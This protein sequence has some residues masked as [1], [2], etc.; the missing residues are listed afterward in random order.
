MTAL[1]APG[2]SRDSRRCREERNFATFGGVKR[3][4]G[5]VEEKTTVDDQGA[6]MVGR[7]KRLFRSETAIALA[8][9]VIVM[10]AIIRAA[11][12]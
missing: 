9:G 6:S 3:S 10:I 4:S 11:G 8:G 2:F 7:A 5:V 1:G 12:G